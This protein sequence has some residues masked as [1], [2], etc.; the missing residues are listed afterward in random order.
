M[1]PLVDR[2]AELS[3]HLAH[4][5]ALRPGWSREALERLEPIDRFVEIVAAMEAE[6]ES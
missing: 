1:S 4:L 3:R 6:E 2:L 5:R